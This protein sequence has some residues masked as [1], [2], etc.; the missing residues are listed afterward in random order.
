MRAIQL[1][2]TVAGAANNVLQVV[3]NRGLPAEV[4]LAADAAQT[5]LAVAAADQPAADRVAAVVRHLEGRGSLREALAAHCPHLPS[6][7]LALALAVADWAT[8]AVG[9]DGRIDAA[10]LPGLLPRLMSE[11]QA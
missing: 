9:K 6:Q 1:L 10:D 4:E 2:G 8:E 5:V 3:G 7:G 11:M